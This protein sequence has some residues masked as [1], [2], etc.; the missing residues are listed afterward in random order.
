MKKLTLT[1]FLAVAIICL[2][3]SVAK[4]QNSARVPRIGFLIP[5]S[6]TNESQ[7][8][9]GF[10]EG[11]RGAGYKEG[12]N[13]VLE[14]QDVKG[15]RTQLERAAKEFVGK[16]V[17]IIFA[18]GTRA[19][20]AAMAA[21]KQIPILFRHPA[22]PV[23]LGFVK[24]LERPGGNVTGVAALALQTNR[25]RLEIFQQV[26]PKLRRI[27]IF[28]DANNRFSPENFAAAEK[29]AAQLKLEVVEYPVKTADELK[30]SLSLMQVKPGDAIFHVPDDLVE[31]QASV[32]FEEAKKQ[33]LATMFHE[34]T[35]AAKGSLAAYG[36]NYYEMG[37]QAAQLAHKII[38]GAK[39]QGLPVEQASKFDLVLNL[40]T[41]RAI[42]LDIAPEM[43][44]KADR[45]IR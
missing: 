11:L 1:L 3:R 4:P 10:R 31:S 26:F 39:P 16:K 18:T 33:R 25:K 38:K 2:D 21:T 45:V 22:D 12:E 42:G 6:G 23:A 13:I 44:S 37:R 43:V 8:L 41:A 7:T 30:S 14:V 17:D 40:R 35:W 19:T 24:S 5:E 15:Q 34:E 32:V 20:Q 29:G 28:Y 36:P 9:K 27:H